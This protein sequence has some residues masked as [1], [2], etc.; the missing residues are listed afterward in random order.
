MHM[1]ENIFFCNVK[2]MVEDLEL[3]YNLLII[4]F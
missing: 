3:C 1:L 4:N 2:N